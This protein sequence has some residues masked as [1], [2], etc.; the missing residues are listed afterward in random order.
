ML[1]EKKNNLPLIFYEFQKKKKFK[2]SI[3]NMLNSKFLNFM[4]YFL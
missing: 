2:Q 4:N 1:Q 3:T